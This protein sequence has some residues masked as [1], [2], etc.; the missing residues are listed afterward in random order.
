MAADLAIDSSRPGSENELPPVI[1]KAAGARETSPWRAGQVTH[2]RGTAG[3]PGKTCSGPGQ[4]K[5][6]RI[7]VGEDK[8]Y[9]TADHVAKLR[10][11]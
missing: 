11:L 8:V 2:V 3:A 9:D 4:R 6:H 1:R 5:R 7:T 10:A